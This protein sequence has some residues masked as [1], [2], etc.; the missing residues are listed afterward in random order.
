MQN[1]TNP[2]QELSL[3]RPSDAATTSAGGEF[4]SFLQL[5]EKSNALAYGL[6]QLGLKK[7]DLCLL[8]LRPSLD[9][10]VVVFALL[11]RGIIPVFIDPG[12]GKKNLLSAIERIRPQ[13]IIAIPMVHALS[14]FYPKIFQSIRFW[15]TSGKITGSR[16][17]SLKQ[18]QNNTQ[19]KVNQRI[20]LDCHE[21]AAILFT[22]G[23]TGVPKGVLYT[24][25][26]FQTQIH[27]LRE[28]FKLSAHDVDL[29]GFPLFSLFSI[30]LG[31]KSVIP[32]MDPTRPAQADGSALVK[33]IKQHGVTFAAG[34]PAIWENVANYCLENKIEL[35]SI[36]YLVMFGAPVP[37]TLIKKFQIIL[38]HGDVYTPYG[39]TEA[40]PL[41]IISGKELL[42]PAIL[43]RH[44][45]GAGTC[46]GRPLPHVKIKILPLE[47]ENTYRELPHSTL[48]E[49]VVSGA[50]V[51]PLYVDNSEETQKSK[52]YHQEQLNHRMGDVGFFDQ[53]GLL[54][55]CGRKSHLI[56]HEGE[57]YATD[58]AEIIF[59]QHPEVK[60]VAFIG[61]IQ[62]KLAL[63]ILRA[64]GR[65]KLSSAE[66]KKFFLE[67][68]ELAAKHPHTHKIQNFF[69][70]KDFPVDV[71]HQIK[72]DRLKLRETIQQKH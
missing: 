36:K 8:F 32:T 60:R 64:D 13:A 17:V 27:A 4:Y 18:L 54:W 15:I 22:S 3:Q 23:G 29:P 71:R 67:L 19:S 52:F 62:S 58:P 20:H 12:M 38:P 47:Q 45:L 57:T 2:L 44:L 42:S 39:A 40:L 56:Q 66:E 51:S 70:Q 33:N 21:T 16:A 65:H 11:K 7:G 1:I 31:M 43:K 50:N 49:I 53:E 41:T 6:D 35:P 14:Y 26:M 25:E 46:V 28:T 55:F 37:Y 9:F 48:G 72:I 61:P 59:L 24:Q 10:P 34:S 30:L 69:L 63:A 5:E 68:R